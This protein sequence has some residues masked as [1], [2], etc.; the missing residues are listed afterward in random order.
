MK[1]FSQQIDHE[2]FQIGKTAYDKRVTIS[3]FPSESTLGS[4]QWI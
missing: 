2:K 4:L 3:L 1:A